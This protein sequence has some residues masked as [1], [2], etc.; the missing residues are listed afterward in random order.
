MLRKFRDFRLKLK[1]KVENDFPKIRINALSNEHEIG[2]IEIQYI[3]N[4]EDT[5]KELGDTFIYDHPYAL[6]KLIKVNHNFQGN[7]I[8][9]RLIEKGLKLIK[10]KFGL[11]NVILTPNNIGDEIPIDKLL[12]FYNKVGFEMMPDQHNIMIKKL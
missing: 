2:F 12:S 5:W 6:I 1:Y 8:G 10:D 3:D 4:E 11:K 9:E 7:G